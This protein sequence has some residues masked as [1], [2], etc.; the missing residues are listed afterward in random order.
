MTPTS[1]D[2]ET[3]P[4]APGPSRRAAL[5]AG[6]G[7]A[8]AAGLAALAAAPAAAS[9][10]RPPARPEILVATNEPWGTYHV[11]PLLAEAE[12]RGW[13]LRQLV[14]D[15]SEIEPGDPVPV[16]TLDDDLSGADLLVVTGAEEWPAECAAAL[17]RLPLAASSLA[18]LR[19]EPAP[20]ARRLR[21]R[22]RLVT[23]SSPAE[24]RAFRSYLGTARP[25]L[26]V[27]SP[28]TDGLPPWRP[29]PGTVLVLTSVTR[30]DPTGGAAPGTELLLAAAA[31]LAA[32]GRRIV[33]GMHPREDPSLWDDY[34]IS[35]VPSVRAAAAAEVAIGIPGTVF[36]LVAAVGAPVVGCTDP[37]LEVPGYLLDVC[38]ATIADA[39]EAVAAV[40]GARPVDPEVLHDAVGPVGGS[41]A[42][43]LD[44]WR[45][46]AR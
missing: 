33:V 45:G 1:T 3:G 24:G 22:L 27:G 30:P 42:R 4:V 34:E 41:A 39:G 10:G 14:P 43:L 23:S 8:L 11:R 5:R 7:G 17:R 28:Q 19:P 16:R 18:Y 12:R 29:E 40:A 37:A 32:E 26:A 36:P 6:L 15:L 46:V 21:P 25:V 9:A 13:R 38:S 20:L 31:R 44:A 2:S 35:P